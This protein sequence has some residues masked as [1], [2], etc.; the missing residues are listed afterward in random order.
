MYFR[1]NGNIAR[2]NCDAIKVSSDKII[3][4]LQN[5]QRALAKVDQY[6]LDDIKLQQI[7]PE[8]DKVV[9][10]IFDE[11][12]GIIAAWARLQIEIYKLEE[13]K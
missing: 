12:N 9:S 11:V 13:D 3:E 4:Q 7:V 1:F 5:V 10:E 2:P 6:S 8:L